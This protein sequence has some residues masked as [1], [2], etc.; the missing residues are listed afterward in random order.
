M[1][2]GAANRTGFR[3]QKATAIYHDY[4]GFLYRATEKDIRHLKSAVII[5]IG[6]RRIL[7]VFHLLL[8][9]QFIKIRRTCFYIVLNKSGIIYF[10][11]ALIRDSVCN[12]PPIIPAATY[13]SDPLRNKRIM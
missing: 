2:P 4:G 6:R 5:S 1:N 10:Q 13:D 11:I 9:C 12:L 8:L 3:V 7:Y